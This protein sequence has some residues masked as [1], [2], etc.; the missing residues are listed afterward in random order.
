MQWLDLYDLHFIIRRRRFGTAAETKQ[1]EEKA[2]ED[3][4]WR[5]EILKE[6]SE[7]TMSILK[8]RKS[9]RRGSC[10]QAVTSSIYP[11]LVPII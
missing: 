9:V 2:A 8:E 11:M 6:N 4:A 10:I 5:M 7:A 3:N 1:Q